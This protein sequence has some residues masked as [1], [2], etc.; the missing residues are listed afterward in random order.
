MRTHRLERIEAQLAKVTS[1]IIRDLKDPR[2]G[3]VSIIRV[4]V[5]PDLQHAKIFVSVMGEPESQ[6]QCID[7]LNS[8]SGFIRRQ[9]F[10]KIEIKN[11]PSLSFHLD[12]SIQES[13]HILELMNRLNLNEPG[14]NAV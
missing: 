14:N 6:N 4:T 2:I 8:A 1:E 11:I 9:L 13:A 10:Q 3:F 5:S 7:G 12:I